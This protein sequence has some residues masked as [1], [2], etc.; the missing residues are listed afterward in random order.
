MKG[1]YE[2]L[3]TKVVGQKETYKCALK[4]PT[5]RAIFLVYIF[6]L[7]MC[8]VCCSC[9]ETKLKL[10]PV[11]GFSFESGGIEGVL[12]DSRR[13]NAKGILIETETNETIRPK[14]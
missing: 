2:S 14:P 10:S 5:F 4:C 13:G 11:T 7:G 3:K 12:I 1:E 6:A 8:I 9:G